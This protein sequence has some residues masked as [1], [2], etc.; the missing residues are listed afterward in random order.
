[1]IRPSL[2]RFLNF[3]DE[4]DLSIVIQNQST[5]SIQAKLVIRTN[6]LNILSSKGVQLNL[7]ANKRKE[8]R[9]LKQRQK[10]LD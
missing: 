3:G 6:N 9:I 8:Y 7:P 4:A 5:Q 10:T 1:M 2:P